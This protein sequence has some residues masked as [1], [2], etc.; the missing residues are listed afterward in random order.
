MVLHDHA[1]G[2]ERSATLGETQ[3]QTRLTH[4]LRSGFG[5]ASKQNWQLNAALRSF[6][7]S[8][9][10]L[11]LRGQNQA[12]VVRDL[13]HGRLRHLVTVMTGHRSDLAVPHV[14]LAN[15]CVVTFS[16]AVAL[17]GRGY[18]P[19][20]RRSCLSLACQQRYDRSG[21]PISFTTLDNRQTADVV[22][23]TAWLLDRRDTRA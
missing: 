8:R 20:T 22:A 13:Q 19:F 2:N 14:G 10:F 12:L 9:L 7:S 23:A 15:A 18:G 5:C 6:A 17:A 4:V 11:V 3:V 16:R 1:F 21:T